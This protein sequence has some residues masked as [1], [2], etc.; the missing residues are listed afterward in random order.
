MRRRILSP[1]TTRSKHWSHLGA[2]P[3][4][5][6]PALDVACQWVRLASLT[7]RHPQRVR[8]RADN[9]PGFGGFPLNGLNG[10][11][12]LNGFCRGLQPETETEA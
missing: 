11:A 2:D 9:P 5:A 7:P 6:Q 1:P 4:G 3:G 10:V 12:G 8:S